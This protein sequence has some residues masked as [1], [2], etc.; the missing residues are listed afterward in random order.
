[1]MKDMRGL[2]FKIYPEAL[3]RKVFAHFDSLGNAFTYQKLS[4]EL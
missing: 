1:M 4:I 3:L 2:F